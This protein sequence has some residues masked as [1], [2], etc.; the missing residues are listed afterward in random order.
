MILPLF[1]TGALNS[2]V[3]T[4]VWLGV[5]VVCW[6]NLRFG[7]SMSG[8]V[9]PGYLVPLLLARPI[10]AVVIVAEGLISYGLTLLLI[11]KLFQRL[12][13]SEMFGR[14]RFFALVLV[15]VMVRI[16]ADGFALPWLGQWLVEQGYEFDYQSNLHSFGL[17]IVALIANQMWNGGLRHG[18]PTLLAY[19]GLTLLIV[20]FGLMEWTNF[21]L[22]NLAFM[23][24]DIASDILASPKAYIVL[25]TTCFLASRMNLRYGWDYAGILIPALLAL[26]WYQPLKLVATFAEAFII[27]FAA[28]QVLRIPL[29]QRMNMEGARLLLLFF[30]VGFAYKIVLGFLLA[31]LAPQLKVSDYYAF[32]YLLST[33]MAM[34]M[35]QKGIAL[36]MTR[37][38]LQ[39]SLAGV[40]LASLVG[41]ALTRWIPGS[42]Q[43]AVAG[44]VT[45]ESLDLM[46]TSN[47][48]ERVGVAR[49]AL[50]SAQPGSGFAPLPSEIDRF[51]AALNLLYRHRQG[52][53]LSLLG[54]AVTELSKLGFV[55]EHIDQR[56][57]LIRDQQPIRGWGI[58]VVDL[59]GLNRLLLEV[60]APLDERGTPSA[61]LA[62]LLDQ[63]YGAL[64]MA[65]TR[66]ATQLD[67]ETVGNPIVLFQRFHRVFG[68]AG[69]VQLRGT[70]REMAPGVSGELWIKR[71][72]PEGLR[73]ESLTALTGP[74]D[75]RF[76]ERPYP[77]R[78]REVM[79][80][81]FAELILNRRTIRGLLGRGGVADAVLVSQS[82]LRIDGYLY[83]WLIASKRQ[84]AGRNSNLYQ[85]P[86]L[87]EL[88]YLEAEVLVPML[89]LLDTYRPGNANL[90]GLEIDRQEFAEELG[91]IA[92]AAQ[93]LGLDLLH[94]RQRG[95]ENEYLILAEPRAPAPIRY[96]GTYVFR[97]G[98][99][100]DMV[101]EVPRPLAEL[102][103]FEYGADLFE[104]TNA[105]VLLIAGA[106]PNANPDGS[107]DVLRLENKLSLFNQV[108]QTLLKDSER[109][110]QLVVQVRAFDVLDDQVESPDAMLALWEGYAAPTVTGLVEQIKSQLDADGVNWVLAEGQPVTRGYDVRSNAQTAFLRFVE[111]A[112]LAVLWL[113]SALRRDFRQPRA[114][115]AEGD[116][117]AA[118]SVPV[119]ELD[120]QSYLRDEPIQVVDSSTR[121]ALIEW[122][123][124][125]KN[126][127][128]V[129][130]AAAL[131]ADDGRWERILDATTGQSVVVSRNADNTVRWICHLRPAE[132]RDLRLIQS[133]VSVDDLGELLG[134]RLRCLWSEAA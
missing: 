39:T 70:S 14:D 8:L 60:P 28:Q 58:Y 22:S 13:S 36:R 45:H 105:R 134:Q 104:R 52:G 127:D 79:R 64:S 83:Q 17:V 25:L 118:L 72:A 106:H 132:E 90:A 50:Y 9:I 10:A 80:D 113:S 57:L 16:V 99:A 114:D 78:Q 101:I 12:G 84:L 115:D 88:L 126:R 102:R 33:L 133:T 23:Y 131:E 6:L 63:G 77:N 31:W 85:P 59:V 93:V 15:S 19:T 65:G 62:L 66:R 123:A 73:L 20:R 48:A 120:L 74:L 41:F 18:L 32:G 100:S 107:A 5:T 21:S 24:E 86:G 111:Q 103:S 55:V 98:V 92:A 69:T 61:A 47:V 42:V 30:N 119:V 112:D 53:D 97:L 81:R 1:P 68:A 124:Y 26:Q 38:V 35:F 4:T 43:S 87:G 130:L 34:K 71:R 75:V 95:S 125:L 82:D 46:Q 121:A 109:S 51:D 96:W 129:R 2:S 44:P 117:L 128:I 3:V 49:S 76:A 56:Y 37:V 94:Y 122:S 116:K 7:T 89:L 40:V 11:D 91:E 54:A 108:H 27:L 67:S 29:F 110:R